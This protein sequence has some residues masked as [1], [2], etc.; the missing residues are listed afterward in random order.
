M[1]KKVVLGLIILGFVLA[2]IVGYSGSTGVESKRIDSYREKLEAELNVSVEFK[3]L[4]DKENS[5]IYN[6][7][8][9]EFFVDPS[10]GELTRIRILS[11]IDQSDMNNLIH[12]DADPV[13][14]RDKAKELF[15]LF[16]T[17]IDDKEDSLKISEKGDAD[18]GYSLV[19]SLMDGDYETGNTAQYGFDPEG[20]LTT[21]VFFRDNSEDYGDVQISYEDARTTAI[22]ECETWT[23]SGSLEGSQTAK[24]FEYK[25]ESYHFQRINEVTYYDFEISA[26]V[27]FSDRGVIEK[28]YMVRVNAMTGQAEMMGWSLN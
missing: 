19:I 5:Y 21:A 14:I 20:V 9:Y 16:I 2:V 27:T 28:T 15:N 11:D 25:E 8:S 17:N 6:S 4:R 24:K 3:E 22:E 1:N 23:L 26:D 12:A 13:S 7:K 10:S 18:I